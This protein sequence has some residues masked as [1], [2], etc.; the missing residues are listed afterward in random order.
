MASTAP[1]SC[2]LGT[3]GGDK[4]RCEGYSKA[5]TTWE[6]SS[7]VFKVVVETHW[8]QKRCLQ[9]EG[10]ETVAPQSRQAIVRRR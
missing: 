9:L 6:R 7:H 3:F 10:I 4:I 1:A 2:P 5:L 8:G